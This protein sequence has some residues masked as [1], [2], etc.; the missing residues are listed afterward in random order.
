MEAN[1]ELKTFLR[2][3]LAIQ[4]AIF[5]SIGCTRGQ[6]SNKLP[7]SD[8][9]LKF[10]GEYVIP[11]SSFITHHFQSSTFGGIVAGCAFP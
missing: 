1:Q 2:H 10:K 7:T 8:F 5:I 9:T 11:Y 4:F 3:F 6:N